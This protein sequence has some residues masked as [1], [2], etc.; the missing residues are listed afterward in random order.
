MLWAINDFASYWHI[1]KKFPGILSAPSLPH[2]LSHIF[3]TNMKSMNVCSAMLSKG[4]IMLSTSS[5]PYSTTCISS[6]SNFKSLASVWKGR[7]WVSHSR[8]QHWAVWR[9]L[10][11]C[12]DVCGT[13]WIHPRN[14]VRTPRSYSEGSGLDEVAS[15]K[16]E[17]AHIHLL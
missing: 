14:V 4:C 1:F 16:K 2:S 7:N 8:S 5:K 6:Q 10:H 15:E 3:N 12:S 17:E 11:I 9:R 13:L